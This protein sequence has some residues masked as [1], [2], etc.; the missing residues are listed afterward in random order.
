MSPTRPST[1]RLL[2]DPRGAFQSRVL[3]GALITALGLSWVGCSFGWDSY[4][5]RLGGASETASSGAGGSGPTTSAGGASSSS[6]TGTGAAVAS[7]SSGS[8]V[9]SSTGSGAGGDIGTSSSSSSS[10]TGGGGPVSC[11]GTS[12]L[13]DD[14]PG[15]DPDELWFLYSNGAVVSETNGE[16]VLTLPSN[17][18][19]GSWGEFDSRRAYDLRGDSISIEITTAPNTSTTAQNWF[20]IGYDDDNYLQIDQKH[21]VLYF[22]QFVGGTK[23]SLKTLS[24]DPVAH[25][26]W[27]FREDGLTTFWETSSDGA[28]WKSMAQVATATLFPIDVMWVWFG[29]GTD[30]GEV[31]PGQVH[32]DHVNGGGAPKEKWCPASSFQ[33]DFNDGTRSLSW[34]RSWEDTPDMMAE[35]GGKLVVTLPPNSTDSASYASAS[36][37]DLTSSSILLE[38]PAAVSSADGSETVVTLLAPGNQAIEMSE[39][40]GHLQLSVKVLGTWQEIASLLYAPAQHR[41]WRIRESANTLYWETAP[42]GKAWSIQAQLSPPPIPVDALDLQIGSNGWQEHPNPGVSSFDNL[43][44]PPP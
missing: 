43:N 2:R 13:A 10:G 38:V 12:V 30:G 34:G 21:G 36:S 14:F 8:G 25:R 32:F 11:G 7:S 28:T 3:G 18:Q 24:F 5:P 20:A 4:D 1:P 17:S 33:D 29:A 31:N 19:N 41:W 37:F 27:R 42:D 22:E 16:A 44:L 39:A 35:T 9:A 26:H 15:G 23:T 6:D 40:Q